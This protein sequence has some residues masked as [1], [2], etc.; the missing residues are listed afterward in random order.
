MKIKELNNFHLQRM[1]EEQ[2][3]ANNSETWNIYYPVNST[4]YNPSNIVRLRIPKSTFVADLS[5]AFISV[6]YIIPWS[7]STANTS[8]TDNIILTS[9]GVETTTNVFTNQPSA[10]SVRNG[11]LVNQNTGCIF[12]IV[13]MLTDGKTLYHDDF[14]QTSV[15]LSSLNKGKDYINNLQQ[16]FVD[17]IKQLSEYN[18]QLTYQNLTIPPNTTSNTKL[19]TYKNI[20]IPL[21]LLFPCF[22]HANDWPCFM[23]NDTIE[24]NL[25]VS[26]GYKY[27][28][29]YTWIPSKNRNAVRPVSDVE[30][31]N[32][33]YNYTYPTSSSTSTAGITFYLDE[34]QLD[35]IALHIPGHAPSSVEF[36]EI[37][38]VINDTTGYLYT[39]RHWNIVNYLSRY[40]MTGET[41]LTQQVN[42]NVATNNMFGVS[43]LALRPGTEVVFDKPVYDTIQ[44]NLGSWELA[45]NGTHLYDN[46][47]YGGDML[48]SVLDNLGQ[49]NL[50]YYDVV[51][52]SVIHDHAIPLQEALSDS[53]YY[54]TGSYMTYWDASPYNELGVGANEFSNLITYKYSVHQ[55]K[56]TAGTSAWPIPNS[57]LQNAKTYCAI[58]TCSGISIT[59]TGIECVNPNSRLL[60]TDF[61]NKLY[62]YS[63]EYSFRGPHGVGAIVAGA[64]TVLPKVI[65]WVPKIFNGIK[66][67]IKGIRNKIRANLN[68]KHMRWF[69]ERLTEK[70]MQ[71][72]MADLEHDSYYLFPKAWKHTY[73]RIIAARNNAH[74]ILVRRGLKIRDLTLPN[75]GLGVKTMPWSGIYRPPRLTMGRLINWARGANTKLA[76]GL[77]ST[78]HGI[79]SWWRRIWRKGKEKLMKYGSTAFDQGKNILQALLS[80][81]ITGNEAKDLAK[82]LLRDTGTDIMS[83]VQNAINSEASHGL[84]P[85]M[86]E[87]WK[88]MNPNRERMYYNLFSR[89]S[90]D[91]RFRRFA[92]GKYLTS[93]PYKVA[94]IIA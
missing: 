63:N 4:V 20:T 34:L 76:H 6:R 29:D 83:D 80:G 56:N 66:N 61:I 44:V 73:N 24:F 68:Y 11:T 3:A 31:S 78:A 50:Q 81:K 70:E 12:D 75:L 54:P 88:T 32:L 93:F 86:L 25:Y 7:S 36:A 13:E 64:A 45:S 57:L 60:S 53:A 65:E 51:Q 49:T 85:H 5:R 22:E 79:R 14:S 39:F 94:P 8:T 23:M 89:R 37:N 41:N 92:K 10:N 21:A 18:S 52:K 69:R 17:P 90:S 48:Q 38:S 71:D 16:T 87:K 19:Y 26:R 30:A 59:P 15:R 77:C 47:R 72:N 35:N 55:E 33:R 27:L 91:F 82:Q 43:M 28:V 58:N 2:I 42:F 1:P 74:G 46:Y 67:G 40:S 62:D 9:N 84:S